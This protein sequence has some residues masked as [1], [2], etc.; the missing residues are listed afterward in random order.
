MG[1][2]SWV[3]VNWLDLRP[4]KGVVKIWL[5]NGYEVQVDLGTGEV[6]QTGTGAR[7]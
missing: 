5:H 4:G 7:T 2:A 1:V 3:D 6:L